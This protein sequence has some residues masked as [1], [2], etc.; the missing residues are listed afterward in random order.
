ML[1]PSL[2]LKVV[3]EWDENTHHL[4]SLSQKRWVEKVTAFAC[5][6]PPT[7]RRLSEGRTSQQLSCN[8]EFAAGEGVGRVNNVVGF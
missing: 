3:Q 6:Y 5:I 2:N 7:S 4:D 1:S 8:G